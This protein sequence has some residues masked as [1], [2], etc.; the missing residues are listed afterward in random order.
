M[1]G[2]IVTDEMIPVLVTQSGTILKSFDM[3]RTFEN[4]SI[5]EKTFPFSEIVQAADGRLVLAGVRGVMRIL[6]DKTIYGQLGA[7]ERRE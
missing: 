6:W 4:V 7:A 1:T 5:K 2:G 3:G